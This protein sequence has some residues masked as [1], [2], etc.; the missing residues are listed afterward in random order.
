MSRWE[1][2]RSSP[3]CWAVIQPLLCSYYMPKCQDGLIDLPSQVIIFNYGMAV[4]VVEEGCGW[5]MWVL[6]LFIRFVYTGVVPNHKE[7]LSRYRA[8]N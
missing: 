6:N 4:C 1:G 7:S 3:R 2:L 8:G 5:T